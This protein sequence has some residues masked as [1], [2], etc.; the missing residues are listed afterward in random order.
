MEYRI[1]EAVVSVTSNTEAK[2]WEETNNELV[3]AV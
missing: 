3:S 1:T 2:V